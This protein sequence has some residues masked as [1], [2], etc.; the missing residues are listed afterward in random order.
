[1]G[2]LLA[3]ALQFAAI[4]AAEHLITH[5]QRRPK[6]WRQRG[7]AK[8]FRRRDA[9]NRERQSSQANGSA[10]DVWVRIEAARPTNM[11]EDHHRMRAGR[12]IFFR[13]EGAP[14]CHLRAQRRKII[15]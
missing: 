11:A 15:A 13:R 3:F 7:Y 2:I 4:P 8:E 14:Q 10:D 5:H 12:L 6:L 9:D 1:E